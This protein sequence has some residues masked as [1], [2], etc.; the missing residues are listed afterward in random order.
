VSTP[1]HGYTNRIRHEFDGKE[2]TAF[3][4]ETVKLGENTI[5]WWYSRVFGWAVLGDNVSIGAGTEIGRGAII[6]N[7]TR[8]GAN[9]FVPNK[10]VIGERVFIGPLVVM[11]DDRHPRILAENDPPY[12]AQPPVIEDDVSIG[13]GAVIL[14]GVRIGQGAR[15]GAGAVVTKDVLAFE[16]VRGEPARVHALTGESKERW[17]A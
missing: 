2:I 14:P 8:I 15:I 6:G 4:D 3:I 9:C 1:A 7:G 16:H 17:R 13:A 5:V 10:A 12:E 11:C